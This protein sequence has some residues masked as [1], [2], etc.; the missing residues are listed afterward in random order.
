MKTEKS[1]PESFSK[2][3]VTVAPSRQEYVTFLTRESSGR[4]GKRK[5]LLVYHLL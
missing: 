1:G 4:T 5:V 3:G 2:A